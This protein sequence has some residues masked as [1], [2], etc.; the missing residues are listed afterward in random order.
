MRNPIRLL[1]LPVLLALLLPACQ[2]LTERSDAR[3]LQDTLDSYAAAARWQPR[4]WQRCIRW[5][6]GRLGRVFDDFHDQRTRRRSCFFGNNCW[7]R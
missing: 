2:S 5:C 6:C 3:K 4:R 1:L 7:F